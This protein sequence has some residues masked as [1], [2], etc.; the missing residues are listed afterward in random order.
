MGGAASISWSG[1]KNIGSCFALTEKAIYA[2]FCA[3]TIAFEG[4]ICYY[5]W[6]KLGGVFRLKEEI[7]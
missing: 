7:I 6:V 3:T 2:K 5:I 4:G 1:I